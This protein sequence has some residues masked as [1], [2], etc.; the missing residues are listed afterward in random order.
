MESVKAKQVLDVEMQV[1][2]AKGQTSLRSKAKGT[3]E[4]EDASLVCQHEVKAKRSNNY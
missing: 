2:V 1:Q 4:R 3:G